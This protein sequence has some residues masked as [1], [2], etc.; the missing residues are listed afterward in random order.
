MLSQSLR[1]GR[2][3]GASAIIIAF[4]M[5]LVMGLAAL[6]I[7]ATGA[8]FN[9]RRQSQT[10]ADTAVMAGAMGYVLGETDDVKVNN[11]LDV[12]R[13]NLDTEY[14]D[15]EWQALWEAC[16]DPDINAVDVGT[17]TPEQFF[18]MANPF[19]SPS[20]PTLECV[21]ESSSYIRVVI[22]NQEVDTT[23]GKVIG[24]DSLETYAVAI[25]RIESD[26][27]AN[28]L[29]PF[30]IPGGAADGEACL[31]TNP[32]G[33]AE[34][35]CQGPTAG[36]F[37]AINSEFF[38]DF[39]GSPSCSFPGSP[40]LAQNVALGIDHFVDVWSADSANAAGVSIGD[41]HPGNVTVGGYSDVS[42]DQC[43][44]VGGVVE[45]QVSGH[46]FPANTLNADSGFSQAA[47]VEEGLISDATFF[48]EPSRLQNT[49]NPTQDLVKRR[50]G[51]NNVVYPLD[52]RG[53][54]DYLT[55]SGACSSASYNGL[56]TDAK[57]ALFQTC[58]SGYS[59]TSDIFDTDI[60]DSPRFAWAPQYWHA[61]AGTSNA[62]YPVE[63][64]RMVFVGGLWFNCDASSPGN[65]G[66]IF[67]PDA[68]SEDGNAE[69]CDAQGSTCQ[70]LNLDQ[71]SAWILPDEAVP[72]SV[73]ASFP[74]GDPSPFVPTLYR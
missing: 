19:P 13:A 30:G 61:L 24:F 14:S 46:E 74:S 65:C 37:G 49:S 1:G 18:P 56:N 31:S 52:D 40:E 71:M 11:V 17:G 2:D 34:P 23:F 39:F 33:T 36:G 60:G 29:L 28:G 55:G 7:D 67:Y 50:Q 6:V 72:D 22:P 73:R 20:T 70:L 43:A 35:P 47:A 5:V 64:Y 66:A 53:P 15:A 3:D 4:T 27:N 10:A 57:V 16:Q 63:Q 26:E 68:D 42:Y 44:I 48:G 32:S 38:G 62:W 59:G 69:I 41:P 58:L 45:P 21:S 54:W 51:A 8:G 12:A 25:A 9:E